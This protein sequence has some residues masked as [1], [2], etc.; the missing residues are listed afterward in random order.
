[1]ENKNSFC[2]YK[3]ELYNLIKNIYKIKPGLYAL[4]KLQKKFE[5]EGIFVENEKILMLKIIDF[6]HSYYQG[7]LLEIGNIKI[8]HLYQLRIKINFLLISH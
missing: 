8:F 2:K 6:N 3:K 7:L 5:S 1:M 4:T